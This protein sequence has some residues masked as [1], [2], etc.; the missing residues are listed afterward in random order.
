MILYIIIYLIIIICYYLIAKYYKL[1]DKPNSRSSHKFNTLIGGGIIFP[2]AFILPFFI[3]LDYIKYINLIIGTTL[4]SIIS[5]VDDIKPISNSKRV[6]FHSIAVILLLTH[7]DILSI[8]I[9]YFIVS[10]ILIIGILNSIKYFIDDDKKIQSRSIDGIPVISSKKIKEYSIEKN[11][12]NYTL[13]IAMPSAN[14]NKIVSIYNN[15]KGS[16]KEIK[17]LPPSS[18]VYR[19][20]PFSQQL[21]KISILDLLARNPNDLDE[22]KILEFIKG[23]TILITGSS[24]TIGGELLKL[25]IK[26][27]AKKIIAIDHNEFG[28][29]ELLE[30]NYKNIIVSVISILNKNILDN[31]FKKHKPNIVL[32]AAA[33][34][35]VHLSEYSYSSTILNN[36]KGTKNIVD[37]SIKYSVSKFVLISTDKAVKPT[38]VMGATKSIAELYCQNVSSLRTDVVCVRFGNVLG[39]SGSVIPKFQSQIDLDQN[40]TVTHKDITRYFMLVNEACNLVLQAA[41]IGNNSEILILDMGNPIKISDLAKKMIDL[42]GKDYL[43][44]EY[45]GLRKVRN[46]MKNYYLTI[47]I[48]KLSTIL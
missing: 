28:Q 18:M 24:G 25:C 33:Y 44:I 47:L 39:S 37:L 12:K 7:L 30:K 27:N 36:I 20:K 43:K 9:L 10:F 23:K 38:N 2:I 45:T 29:Y 32:H 11:F 6:L 16:F 5:F 8:N 46:Y 19:D 41:S 35:H 3:E 26:N 17:I 31:L 40:I 48:K 13:I 4:V 15:F 22:R 34:K 21:K 42:S 1:Y 14:N